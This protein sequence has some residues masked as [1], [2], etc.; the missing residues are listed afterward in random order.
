MEKNSISLSIDHSSKSPISLSQNTSTIKEKVKRLAMQILE[1]IQIAYRDFKKKTD[2]TN[3][4][5]WIRAQKP[6]MQQAQDR[7]QLTPAAF[8]KLPWHQ[9]LDP[10]Y[11]RSKWIDKNIDFALVMIRIFYP[12]IKVTKK[13]LDEIPQI[14]EA[15]ISNTA[16]L[17]RY[18]ELLEKKK[19]KMEKFI[20][21][22]RKVDEEFKSFMTDIR[23]KHRDPYGFE[24][25]YIAEQNLRDQM[26]NDFVGKKMKAS[27][28]THT[29]RIGSYLKGGKITRKRKDSYKKYT[30]I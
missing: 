17:H 2:E 14:L 18:C 23:S 4:W 29:S 27:G 16:F 6:Q 5:L 7:S 26:V 25:G 24:L 28:V 3:K 9:F 15:F 11:I 30:Y 19:S 8:S 21:L 13:N 1:G 12:K 22:E 10:D 20:K